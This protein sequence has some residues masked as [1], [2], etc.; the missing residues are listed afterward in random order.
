MHTD[1]QKKFA[2]ARAAS[3]LGLDG[4]LGSTLPEVC[5]MLDNQQTWQLARNYWQEDRRALQHIPEVDLLEIAKS[6]L[7][8]FSR[9]G[10]TESF[11]SDFK[12]ILKDL[13]INEPPPEARQFKT[14]DPLSR[15]Q[16]R[17]ATLDSL[18]NRLELDY[19]LIDSVRQKS[20][21]YSSA[22][23]RNAPINAN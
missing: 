13:N 6:H 19:A 21:V 11:T 9:V 18:K 16:L 8:E 12:A 1:M 5:E 15:D 14:V 17:P 2:V 23:E 7:A 3:N 22:K 20:P 10:L 4:F